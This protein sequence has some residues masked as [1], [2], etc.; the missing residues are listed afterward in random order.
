MKID[1]SDKEATLL[2]AIQH[3]GDGSIGEI[4]KL[5]G[6]RQHQITYMLSRL[7]DRG[8]ILGRSLFVD[9]YRLGYTYF[10]FSFS[11][12]SER[13]AKS[14]E[15][16]RALIESPNV[17]FVGLVGGEFQYLATICARQVDDVARF[18]EAISRRFGNFILEKSLG[19]HIAFHAYG[20]RYLT[21]RKMTYPV[22][23]YG[24]RGQYECKLSPIEHR[25]LSIL[26]DDSTRSLR[27]IARQIGVPPSTVHRHVQGLR[28]EGVIRGEIYRISL[29]PIGAL[30]FKLLVFARGINPEVTAQLESFC[31]ND[32]AVLRFID[33][34]GNWD[35]E[36]DIEVRQA[37]EMNNFTQRLFSV[38]GQNLNSIKPL[39]IFRHLK[40]AGYPLAP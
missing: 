2:A 20:R 31:R 28:D 38:M 5:T 39:Q 30:Q 21:N 12:H 25:A 37:E 22:M 40:F 16:I 15:I 27:D 32:T 14:D 8:V 34:L 26:S 13:Q 4:A 33:C 29:R 18:L 19:T 35:Y 36:I 9:V 3:R 24:E 17:A 1:L 23:S 10:T 7:K 6:Q 11:F